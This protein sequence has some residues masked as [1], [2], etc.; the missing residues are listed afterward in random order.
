MPTS[1][2][3]L[4]MVIA[5]T[6]GFFAAP[7]VQRATSEVVRDFCRYSKAMHTQ[8]AAIVAATSI[9]ATKNQSAAVAITPIADCEPFGIFGLTVNGRKTACVERGADSPLGASPIEY[10][11]GLFFEISTPTTCRIHPLPGGG[12]IRFFTAFL[13]TVSAGQINDDLWNRY[14][15]GILAG[16]KANLLMTTGY[17]S[18]NPQMAIAFAA[19]FKAARKTARGDTNKKLIGSRLCC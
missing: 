6:G 7:V 16:I 14:G 11:G 17:R 12:D 10:Q 3:I 15:Q 4:D 9:D 1:S 13:P 5:D 8:S 18:S 2:A 19:E